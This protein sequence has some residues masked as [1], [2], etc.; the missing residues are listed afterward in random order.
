MKRLFVQGIVFLCL[1]VFAIPVW[2]L[3]I[4]PLEFSTR[5][6]NS[7]DGAVLEWIQDSLKDPTLGFAKIDTNT[8]DWSQIGSST[9]FTHSLEGEPAYFFVKIGLGQL[10][11]EAPTHFIFRNLGELN[12]AYINIAQ[13]D[14]TIKGIGKISYIGTI[15]EPSTLILLGGGLLGLAVY[16]RRRMKK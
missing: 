7:G 4:D 3:T 11:S 10:D 8:S 14:F 5:F 6:T 2:S 9:V 15:P 13:T 16:G 12:Y 1:F